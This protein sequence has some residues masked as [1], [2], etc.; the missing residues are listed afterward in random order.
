M[1]PLIGSGK[2]RGRLI[3]KAWENDKGKATLAVVRAIENAGKK[4]NATVGKR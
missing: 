3:Y 4:F 2:D 1:G